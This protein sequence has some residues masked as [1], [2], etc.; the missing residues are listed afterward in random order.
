MDLSRNKSTP[1][2]AGKE[3]IPL[4]VFSPMK[5]SKISTQFCTMAGFERSQPV[6]DEAAIGGLGG[7]RLIK[8]MITLLEAVYIYRKTEHNPPG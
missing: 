4:K 8:V 3:L 2:P 1:P 6:N 7:G 5:S